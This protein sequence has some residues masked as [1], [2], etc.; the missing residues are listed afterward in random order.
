MNIFIENNIQMIGTF[1]VLPS[2][3]AAVAPSVAPIESAIKPM[4]NPKRYPP[5]SW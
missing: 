5:P 3:N 4:G 1:T 2:R